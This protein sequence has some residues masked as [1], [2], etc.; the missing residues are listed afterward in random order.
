M[1]CCPRVLAACGALSLLLLSVPPLPVF[2]QKAAAISVPKCHGLDATIIGNSAANTLEGT[3]GDDVIYGDGG[4][5]TITGNGGNDTICGGDGDDS[6]TAGSGDDYVEGGNGGD[7][8]DA[9]DGNNEVKGGS[10]Q[11]EIMAGSGDDDIQGNNGN[12]TIDAGNGNNTVAGGTGDDDIH[13]GSGND[14]I[15]SHSG[16][17]IV[18]AGSGYDVLYGGDGDDTLDGGDD[19]DYCSGEDGD[20]TLSNCEAGDGQGIIIIVKD[21]IPN[22]EQDFAFS[23]GDS[24]EDAFILDDDGDTDNDLSNTEVLVREG[25]DEYYVTEEEVEGWKLASISCTNNQGSAES[26]VDLE[27]RS[28]EVEL[29]EADI[30]TCIFTNTKAARV[31]IVKKTEDG[32][33]EFTF[34]G[35]GEEEP[36]IETEDGEGE[37]TVTVFPASGGTEYT[38]R[39]NVPEDWDLMEISCEGVEADV[40]SPSATF[41]LQPGDEVT[42][43]F[44]NE[45]EKATII[46]MK[47][48]TGGDGTFSI[49]SNSDDIGSFDLTTVEGSAERSFSVL[50]DEETTFSFEETDLPEG[51]V[52]SPDSCEVTVD[53]GETAICS[54]GNIKKARLIIEKDTIGGDGTFTFVAEGFSTDDDEDEDCDGEEGD[55]DSEEDEFSLETQEH[56]AETFFDIFVDIESS[57]EV[58]VTEQSTDG[59]QVVGESSCTVT[60]EPGEVETCTFTNKQSDSTAP[61][62][63]FDNSRDHEVIQTEIVALELRGTSVDTPLLTEELSTGVR[64][65]TLTVRKIGGAE[66]VANF[67]AQ[68]FF[69]VFTEIDCRNLGEIEEIPIEI[70]A[71][72]LVSVDPITVNW[73]PS[74]PWVP[75][76]MGMYCFE[77]SAT[78][79][80]GNAENTAFAGPIAYV[81]VSQIS[82]QETA[83]AKEDGFTVNWTTD[84]PATSRIIYD[85]VPHP[86]LG[87][88][89]NYGY[90]FST[91][92]TNTDPKITSHSVVIG[93]LAPG[94]TY[95]Y[96]T[97]SKASPESVGP[98]KSTTTSSSSSVS[99]DPDGPSGGAGSGH[100][101]RTAFAK[102]RFLALFHGIGD[103]PPGAFG[104]G[105][106]VPLGP[107]EIRFV[108]SMQR[109]LPPIPHPGL[110]ELIGTH[111][112]ALMGR[113]LAFI[114]EQLQDP[115]L[116]E[117]INTALHLVPQ[118]VVATTI[119][120]PIGMDGIPLS[121]NP[122]WNACIRGEVT[123]AVIRN[124]PDRD[125]DGR[126]EDCAS[127][128]T[129][130][131]WRHPDL[132]MYFVFERSPLRIELPKGYVLSQP[133]K[134]ES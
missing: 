19:T 4:N 21:A 7:S 79:N 126:P 66:S 48:T 8:I 110:L 29:A 55:C 38:V 100:G 42:C 49:S 3:S 134:V 16:D 115:F 63:S 111:M 32:D 10:G 92:E 14:T 108:C 65:V 41:T 129:D 35:P 120:F 98:E 17:D 76:D 28:V 101:S 37:T 51:W 119:P 105:P 107:E 82:A 71:L 53:P 31:T 95:Y 130:N 44:R 50:I 58:T 84:K 57:K 22:D 60:L 109:S 123:L 70:V 2:V 69:D 52:G 13:T 62:S 99:S 80:A 74:E 121:R 106:E 103:L 77:A 81:P 68:S 36:E 78:D 104:A 97:V 122:S 56:H 23:V 6:I 128:S 5:D 87:E 33:E 43:T 54:L 113:D 102:A 133:K 47:E 96:R 118:T 114:V 9:G 72:S 27:N 40:D 34:E 131:V 73:S 45:R 83:D 11:D 25:D 127:Y 1:R 75:R 90:A 67:P 39:E 64:N 46:V 24:E 20:N 125:E 26:D 89:P 124:N 59:W 112:A 93:G 94:I 18:A 86:D 15:H 132:R 117:S 91:P 85:T 88:A 30:I 61:Q 116:C 12:D